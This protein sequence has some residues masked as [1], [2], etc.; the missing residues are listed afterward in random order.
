MTKTRRFPLLALI[1]AGLLL[2]AAT[3]LADPIRGQ[4]GGEPDPSFGEEA[5]AEAYEPEPETFG[6]QSADDEM[7]LPEDVAG[8]E[9]DAQGAIPTAVEAGWTVIENEGFDSLFRDTGWHSYDVNGASVG[10]S[11]QWVTTTRRS[12]AG[13]LSASPNGRANYG[14]NEHTKM[15]F[16]PFSLAGAIDAKFSFLYYLNTQRNYDLLSWE[17]SCDARGSWLSQQKSGVAG[18]K[19]VTVSLK[20]CLGQSSV[21]VQFTFLS[22][23]SINGEG[24]YVDSV[25]IQKLQ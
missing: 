23:V 25:L 18:W 6:D 7:L 20:P 12:F 15:Y 17:Y 8:A 1:V 2:I 11:Y 4:G 10:G 16:G 22:D 21:Y 9:V 14:Q 5:P 19:F 3:V 13:A 24:A